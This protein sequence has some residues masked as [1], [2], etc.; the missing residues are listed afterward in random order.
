MDL[1]DNFIFLDSDKY[2]LAENEIEISNSRHSTNDTILIQCLEYPVKITEISYGY[3]TTTEPKEKSYCYTPDW[4]MNKIQC[5][6]DASNIT[7]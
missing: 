3:M 1:L 5:N 4:Y 6:N 7:L 2:P